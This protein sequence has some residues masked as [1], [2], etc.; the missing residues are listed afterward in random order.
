MLWG[1]FMECSLPHQK[2]PINVHK[3]FKVNN[4][5]CWM[6]TKNGVYTV[7]SRAFNFQ[8]KTFK[9]PCHDYIRVGAA[10]KI[11]FCWDFCMITSRSVVFKISHTIVNC[12][13]ILEKWVNRVGSQ[14][15]QKG[16][17]FY[18]VF[19]VLDYQ[20]GSMYHKLRKTAIVIYPLI[21]FVKWSTTWVRVEKGYVEFTKKKIKKS[22]RKRSSFFVV[23]FGQIRRG[24]QLMGLKIYLLA[25]ERGMQLII[26]NSNQ[27]IM[28]LKIGI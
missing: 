12:W 21:T 28:I 9:S 20:F 13:A 26:L 18:I 3:G 24:L 10:P 27:K 8:H 14:L 5:M 23:V 4:I 2:W 25:L 17:Q 7:L 11:T 19:S 15:G 6:C 16:Y 1:I 22:F